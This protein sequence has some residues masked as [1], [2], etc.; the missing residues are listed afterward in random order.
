[1]MMGLVTE[2]CVGGRAPGSSSFVNYSEF[3]VDTPFMLPT[4]IRP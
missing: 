3:R 4:L 2:L 1:M